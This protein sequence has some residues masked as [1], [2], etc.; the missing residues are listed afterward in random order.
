MIKIPSDSFKQAGKL[1]KRLPFHRAKLP[2]F[3][4]VAL[5]ADAGSQ[6][7]TLV[8]ATLDMRVETTVP[9]AEPLTQTQ[10]FLLPPD[11]LRTAL[12]AD[13]GSVLHLTYKCSRKGRV[14]RLK[15]LCG[16]IP[17]ETNHQT[18][19]LADFPTRPKVKGAATELPARTFEML[20]VVATCASSDQTRQILNGVFFTPDDGGLLVATDGRRLAGSPAT[21]P[22]AGSFILPNG[23]VH[24]LGHPDFRKRPATVTLTETESGGGEE[25]LVSF[26]SED[27]LVIS[28]TLP[29]TY[30]NWKQ[31]VP[32]D[33]VSSLTITDDR[34]P[35]LLTWLRSLRGAEGS[36]TLHRK[37]RGVLQLVH[38][39][40]GS[41]TATV[42]VPMEQSGELQPISLDP[43]FL[44]TALR[45]APTLWFTDSMSPVIARRADGAFC[46]IMPMRFTGVPAQR[47]GTKAS[48][49]DQAAA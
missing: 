29:G 40:R 13:R 4:H 18:L 7:A 9:L 27:H 38:S 26:R 8:V 45:I 48:S 6:T 24:V 25:Q 35:A 3:T 36:V 2:V 37:R 46:V 1:L 5:F 41:I 44:A 31:V 10:S 16:G 22:A 42:E 17:V 21:V 43:G 23:A 19:D 47:T 32:R 33:M 30:P 28:K 39:D 49:S 11:A 20:A 15:A 14:L 12:Q 34:R